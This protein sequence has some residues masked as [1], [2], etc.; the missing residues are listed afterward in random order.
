MA[1]VKITKLTKE[2]IEKKGIP[3]WP[4]WTKEIS[5]FDWYY[6]SAEHCQI[7]EGEVVVHTDEG[8]FRIHAG[9]FVTFEKGLKCVWEVKKPIRKHY[10]FD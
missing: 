10:N 2:E 4:V 3:H 5:R 1:K 9:D 6:D 8:D 7:L